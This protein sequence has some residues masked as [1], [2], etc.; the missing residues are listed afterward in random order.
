MFRESL[1]LPLAFLLLGFQATRSVGIQE[2]G[3]HQVEIDSQEIHT[4]NINA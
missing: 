4:A 3:M 2:E 1:N